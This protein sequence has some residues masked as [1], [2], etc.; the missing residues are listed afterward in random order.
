MAL[1]YVYILEQVDYLKLDGCYNNKS[2]FV[3]GYP[4][5]GA[6]LQASGNFT[7]NQAIYDRTFSF[8]RWIAWD[9]RPRHR[10]L[11]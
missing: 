1:N 7:S 4:A 8:L 5:M 9:S 11:M 6:G 2:G 10:L 3:T